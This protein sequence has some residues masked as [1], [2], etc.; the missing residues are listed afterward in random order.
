MPEGGYSF[1][2]G[3]VEDFGEAYRWR[4]ENQDTVADIMNEKAADQGIDKTYEQAREEAADAG[5]VAPDD[6]VAS[7]II[8]R[9]TTRPVV[10]TL[11]YETVAERTG[12]Y[13]VDEGLADDYEIRAVTLHD[14]V[15]HKDNP[16]ERSRMYLTYFRD[17]DME[18][19]R[20]AKPEQN[21]RLT[22]HEL[23]P[24]LAR[25]VVEDDAIPVGYD[26]LDAEVVAAIEAEEDLSKV[27][28]PI[29]NKVATER[30]MGDKD[31]FTVGGDVRDLYNWVLRQDI[32]AAD[33]PEDLPQ[34][35]TV[36]RDKE[37][38]RRR[39]S[40]AFLPKDMDDL[41]RLP[42]VEATADNLPSE[43]DYSWYALVSRTETQ[44]VDADE[45]RKLGWYRSQE[46]YPKAVSDVW[47]LPNTAYMLRDGLGDKFTQGRTVHYDDHV[48][49]LT[50][51]A[52]TRPPVIDVGLPS[53]NRVNGSP[54]VPPEIQDQL[55]E[56]QMG[57]RV[58][59]LD[60][61]EDRYDVDTLPMSVWL[62]DEQWD[63]ARERIEAEGLTDPDT[64]PHSYEDIAS[65]VTAIAFDTIAET[66]RAESPVLE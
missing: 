8:A 33:S 50:D 47:A 4:L 56:T 13:L 64:G 46:G 38:K 14:D 32:Q 53:H 11:I 12:Q 34:F 30:V 45:V 54:A 6:D 10:E 40:Y 55:H 27:N 43:D 57:K 18:E 1:I 49:E 58:D 44:E 61:G 15:F 60:T 24:Q 3:G 41:G 35:V 42:D 65:A 52:V 62:N 21:W 66:D 51:G 5:L 31:R 20:I 22:S 39:A 29:F 23:H 63:V 16:E 9:Q 7:F 17:G 19:R 37:G 59:R 48:A 28:V 36:P 2:Q 25:E 26:D